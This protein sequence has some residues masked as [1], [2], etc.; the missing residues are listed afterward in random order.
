MTPALRLTLRID[1]NGH[2]T[3]GHGKI[4]LLEHV[5]ATGSISAAGRAMGMSYRRAWL[6][7]DALNNQFIHPLV[8][9]KP[10][11][12]GGAKLSETGHAV[13]DGYRAAEKEAMAGAKS[14]LTA[15]AGLVKRPEKAAAS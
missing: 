7:I 12:G 9:T 3:L 8:E 15:L 5:A 11:G 2:P 13:V 10:G 1:V 4:R 14:S 6:L